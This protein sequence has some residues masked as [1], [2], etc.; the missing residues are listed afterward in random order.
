[1]AAT[2]IRAIARLRQSAA[3]SLCVLPGVV[4]LPESRS[5]PGYYRPPFQGFQLEPRASAEKRWNAVSGDTAYNNPSTTVLVI[6][7]FLAFVQENT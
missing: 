4:A 1:M 5:T 3:E 6:D 2:Q 7:L